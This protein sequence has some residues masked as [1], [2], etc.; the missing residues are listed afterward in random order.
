M[1]PLVWFVVGWIVGQTVRECIEIMLHRRGHRRWIL[2]SL[3][4]ACLALFLTALICG[5]THS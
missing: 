1:K 5:Q 2:L 4:L 3:S